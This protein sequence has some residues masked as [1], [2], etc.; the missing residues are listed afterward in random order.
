M[1]LGIRSKHPGVETLNEQSSKEYKDEREERERGE[2]ERRRWKVGRWKV[3]SRT[4]RSTQSDRKGEAPG[5][6]SPNPSTPAPTS[7]LVLRNTEIILE[8]TFLHLGPVILMKW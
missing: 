2:K 8:H 5:K 3:R 7:T 1:G 6:F 4:P